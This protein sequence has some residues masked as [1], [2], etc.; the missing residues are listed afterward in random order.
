M[1]LKVFYSNLHT[2]S[3][4]SFAQTDDSLL[5]FRMFTSY[6]REGQ[7]VT[8]E[9]INKYSINVLKP[10]IIIVSDL[11]GIDSQ[12]NYTYLMDQFFQK[13]N[14]NMFLV[15]RNTNSQIMYKVDLNGFSVQVAEFI[16]A[17]LNKTEPYITIRLVGFKSG[18][19]ISS[20]AANGIASSFQ[21]KISRVTALE[22]TNHESISADSAQFVDVLHKKDDDVA[23]GSADI[24][25]GG[26][27]SSTF[28]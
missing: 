27:I 9:S 18:G 2:F 26:K 15:T 6:N 5:H 11:M 22:P 20:T 25:V 23:V 7:L 10:V 24:Y 28:S 4:Y 17:L 16:S 13:D 3:G 21:R 1:N 19:A 14:F 8:P 12:E